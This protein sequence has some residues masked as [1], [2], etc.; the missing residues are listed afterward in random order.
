MAV[1]TK[2]GWMHFLHQEKQRPCI[3]F[4]KKDED[5]LPHAHQPCEV[6]VM[7]DF[8][9]LEG[10]L[11]TQGPSAKELLPFKNACFTAPMPA[12]ILSS[13]PEIHPNP[14]FVPGL[15]NLPTKGPL[16]PPD[17]KFQ[18]L[19][20]PPDTSLN[21]SNMFPSST[22]QS[23][24][25]GKQRKRQG[26]K[27]CWTFSVLNSRQVQFVK[28]TNAPTLVHWISD[29]DSVQDVYKTADQIK[30]AGGPIVREP[31]PVPGIGTKVTATTDPDG[32][33]FAFVDMS[34]FLK[35][36]TNPL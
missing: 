15:G 21:N 6:R 13:C 11:P 8:H 19:D 34:D 18:P 1:S 24:E 32:W 27:D 36:F 17:T 22:V 16:T 25:R 26:E 5:S 33:R 30:A 9:V 31:G 28:T 20:T 12:S 10:T 14:L 29:V 35:E 7:A 4:T 2:V 23:W 3:P